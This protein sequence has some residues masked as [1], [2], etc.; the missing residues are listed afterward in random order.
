MVLDITKAIKERT[1][2][3]EEETIA[4]RGHLHEHPE[5]GGEEVETAKFLKSSC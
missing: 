5:V 1:L 3:L 2:E 4:I